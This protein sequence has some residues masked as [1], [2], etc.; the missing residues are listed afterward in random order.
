MEKDAVTVLFIKNNMCYYVMVLIISKISKI[1]LFLLFSI[2]IMVKSTISPNLYFCV[3]NWTEEKLLTIFKKA[4]GKD[5]IGVDDDFFEMGGTSLSVSKVAMLALN[6]DLPIAYGD[7]FDYPTVLELEQY[8]NSL[9][10]VSG[11]S[12]NFLLIKFLSS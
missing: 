11:N 10:N 3:M 9:S 5:N 2:S 7:V 6:M 4:L 8:I 12:N 1:I